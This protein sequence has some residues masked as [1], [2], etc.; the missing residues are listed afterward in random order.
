MIGGGLHGGGLAKLHL[1]LG[2]Q[3]D[4]L[5]GVGVPE[6]WPLKLELSV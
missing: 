1:H 4:P 2:S 5:L 6:F 3:L